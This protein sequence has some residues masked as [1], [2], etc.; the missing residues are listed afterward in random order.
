[1]K[2][3]IGK[4]TTYNG[5]EH[6]YLKGYKVRIV[7]VMR[8]SLNPGIEDDDPEQDYI[9]DEDDLARAGGVTIF[10]R[11]EVQPWLEKEGRFS[12]V[13]S[14]PRAQDLACFKHLAKGR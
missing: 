7:A 1:M 14:D 2:K 10:D 13:T 11:I 4:V 5:T 9:R 12:F 8:N 3:I 6:S